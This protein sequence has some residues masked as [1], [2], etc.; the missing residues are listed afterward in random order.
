MLVVN[1]MILASMTLSQEDRARLINNPAD[2][3]PEIMP[4]LSIGITLWIA[5]YF[6]EYSET[7]Y[8]LQEHLVVQNY[9]N[10]NSWIFVFVEVSHSFHFFIDLFLIRISW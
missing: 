2:I 9:L 4:K 10:S 5:M 3:L 8:E 1:L 7:I 6:Y